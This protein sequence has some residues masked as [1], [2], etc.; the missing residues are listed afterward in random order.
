MK[1]SSTA[2]KAKTP[3]DRMSAYR[4]RMR[5]KGYRQV[6][7]WVPDS[8]SPEVVERARRQSAAIS[9][10]DADEAELIAWLDGIRAWP[11][12]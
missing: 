7:L 10:T 9:A 6:Q 3:S 2:K 11:E 5:E 12:D 8:R 1:M 4:L